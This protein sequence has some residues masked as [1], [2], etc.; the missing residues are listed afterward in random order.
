MSILTAL[1]GSQ[2]DNK[3]ARFSH[4]DLMTRSIDV[5]LFAATTN[6]NLRCT[7]CA[8]SLPDYVGEDFDVSK[9]DDLASGFARANVRL[10]QIS[11]HGETTILPN[12]EKFALAFEHRGIPTCITSNFSKIFSDSEIDALAQMSHITISID[13]V[14]RELLQAVRRKVDL[15]TILYNMSRIRLCAQHHGRVPNFNWQCTLSDKVYRGLRDW[16]DLGILNGV[17]NFTLGNLIELSA[18]PDTPRHVAK[19]ER[20]EL[21][22][23][24]RIIADVCNHA[25]K[26][27]VWISIQ[28]G[29]IEGINESLVA[30]G[31]NEPFSPRKS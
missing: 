20:D 23:A 31:V 13:T 7:Y 19:M 30:R 16:M 25:S 22:D 11:G 9:L 21:L 4:H 5:V 8:V 14:D 29:I 17:T 6:C 15:R 10:V 18:L 28:P 27:G 1:R 12:W 3:P 2:S 26:S 24:C